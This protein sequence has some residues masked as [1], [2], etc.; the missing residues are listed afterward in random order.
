MGL[1]ASLAT[2]FNSLSPVRDLKKSLDLCKDH[3]RP[4]VEYWC[5]ALLCRNSISFCWGRTEKKLLFNLVNLFAADKPE[6]VD[7][8]GGPL[9]FSHVLVYPA[10]CMSAEQGK[11]LKIIPTPDSLCPTSKGQCLTVSCEY[12]LS[13]LVLNFIMS[14]LKCILFLLI[15]QFSLIHSSIHHN[16]AKHRWLHSILY[17]QTC[18]FT[19]KMS[20]WSDDICWQAMV[21]Y[22][23]Q[24]IYFI[25][26]DWVPLLEIDAFC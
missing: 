26:K 10:L 1:W 3:I 14:P 22:L 15:S 16:E 19:S 21:N 5:F 9:P 12:L 13:S 6:R 4:T 23:S 20:K 18:H 7:A 25:L 24:F 11:R 17:V 2:V 8:V